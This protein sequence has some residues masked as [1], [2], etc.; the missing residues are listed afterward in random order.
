ML[1]DALHRRRVPRRRRQVMEL[2]C[3]L[4]TRRSLRLRP[5]AVLVALH[6]GWFAD[7]R[8]RAS[9]RA[10][11]RPHGS[12]AVRSDSLSASTV[13]PSAPSAR[14]VLRR[15]SAAFDTAISSCTGGQGS[16]SLFAGR[17]HSDAAAAGV[18][19]EPPF[20]DALPASHAGRP[21]DRCRRGGRPA[22]HETRGAATHA[23]GDCDCG[24][25]ACNA[26]RACGAACG[27]AGQRI[28]DWVAGSPGGEAGACHGRIP[29]RALQLSAPREAPGV[30]AAPSGGGGRPDGNE[31]GG[32]RA[33]HPLAFHVCWLLGRLRDPRRGALA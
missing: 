32:A 24:G 20:A 25:G 31:R 11:V 1:V 8:Q 15:V 28:F 6:G 14:R 21:P 10:E 17:P 7:G 2:W 5:P 13:R 22:A 12:S 27:L 29:F 3:H 26:R 23:N 16:G 19:A 18:G 9:G 33:G 4:G 30:G